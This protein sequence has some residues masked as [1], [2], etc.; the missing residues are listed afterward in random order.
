MNMY[1]YIYIYIYKYLYIYIYTDIISIC[2]YIYISNIQHKLN[3]IHRTSRHKLAQAHQQHRCS[4]EAAY[5]QHTS[6]KNHLYI[7]NYIY[8]IFTHLYIYIQREQAH[9]LLFSAV[10]QVIQE[11]LA[12]MG[13]TFEHQKLDSRY[14]LLRQRRN[15]VWGSAARNVD[16]TYKEN[17]QATVHAMSSTWQFKYN[18]VFDSSLEQS[19]ELHERVRT[20]LETAHL[21]ATLSGE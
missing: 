17:L 5:K 11:D 6:R 18:D 9:I 4:T 21:K 13:Y 3:C 15:R 1:I 8:I 2:I 10:L 7:Y 19:N 20:H 12:K 14:Y 16:E